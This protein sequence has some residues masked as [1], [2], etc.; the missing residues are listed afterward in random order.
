[1][2]KGKKEIHTYVSQKTKNREALV[3]DEKFD[4]TK[5]NRWHFIYIYIYIYKNKSI[6]KIQTNYE[7]LIV[8]KDWTQIGV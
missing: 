5:N 4:I 7:Q 2:N 3:C 1:M 8:R 6:F